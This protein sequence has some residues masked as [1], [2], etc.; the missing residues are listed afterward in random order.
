MHTSWIFRIV[1]AVCVG[2]IFQI[3]AM[4]ALTATTDN[5]EKIAEMQRDIAVIKETTKL[6]LESQKESLQKDLQN[7][8]SKIEQQDKRV[9]DING[10]TDRLSLILSAFGL[11]ITLLAAVAGYAA[12]HSAGAKAR[13]VAQDWIRKHES[14]LIGE[15][16]EATGR[17]Q[18]DAVQA[19][20][21]I[22]AHQ[23]EVSTAAENAK[24]QLQENLTSTNP[25]APTPAQVNALD[26]Q[27]RQ[28]KQKPESEYTFKDWESRALTAYAAKRLD[29][30]ANF[31]LEASKSSDATQVQVSR[32]LDSRG[33]MFDQLSRYAEAIDV[34]DQ[35]ITRFSEASELVL[36][37]EVARAMVNKGISLGSLTHHA[38]A[39]AVY[40]QVI[41]RFGG[42]A[43]LALLEQVARA[44]VNKGAR[45]GE[46]NRKEDG[47]AVCDQVIA[48]F[49]KATALALREAVAR[50]MVIKSTR[51]GELD[52]SEDAIAVSDQVI[53]LFGA[54]AEPAL[55]EQVAQA[56]NNLGFNLL[57][58]AKRVWSDAGVRNQLLKGARSK[59]NSS[60][61]RHAPNEMANGNLGYV[62]FLS[63]Q[64][65]ESIE[66]LRR[67]LTLGGDA[68]YRATIKDTETDTVPEDA[69]FRALLEK[70]WKEIQA[71]KS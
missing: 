12:W 28:L 32:S 46:L 68:L 29:L 70:L 35:V 2:C 54:A 44:M 40:D 49:G 42:A 27:E 3:S 9:A 6:Q 24:K 15:G 4:A 16:R 7:L 61:E 34:F 39:I 22:Q 67:A 64:Q 31:F 52:L 65:E 62:L 20:R 59:F 1:L 13:E 8:Q 11:L 36:R 57:L 17:V 69:A 23:D 37:E 21:K 30:A 71:K 51:L 53:A 26:A 45:L 19:S 58:K 41:D 18:A 10:A 14:E 66:P 50:A 60:L 48:R 56:I 63:G 47:I 55:R 43:E 38:E 25:V 33:V 5:A